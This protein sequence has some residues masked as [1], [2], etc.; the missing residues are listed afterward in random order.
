MNKLVEYVTAAEKRS[1]RMD[2][3]TDNLFSDMQRLML[4][5]IERT[6]KGKKDAMLKSAERIY[7]SEYWNNFEKS[8]NGQKQT[9]L[10]K[11]YKI[12][13]AEI[14]QLKSIYPEN[15][16][17][18]SVLD[19]AFEIVERYIRE[20][21]NALDIISSSRSE[22]LGYARMAQA[23]MFLSEVDDLIIDNIE[24]TLGKQLSYTKTRVKFAQDHYY[25]QIRQQLFMSVKTSKKKQ[26]MYV[27]VTD[28]KTRPFC[29][30]NV[31]K[32]RTKAEWQSINNRMTG[33]AWDDD[34]G[35]NCRH[36]KVLVSESWTAEEI[37]E[38]EEVFLYKAA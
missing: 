13:N 36:F 4:K 18:S 32:I 30:E 5:S 1:A 26:Y 6:L 29:R 28:S 15:T 21:I 38:A 7:T 20:D 11:F 16:F 9:L 27:G 17:K 23:K 33:N 24:K 10:D 37:K 8:F 14:N 12:F 25:N 19:S 31:G 35:W 34:G 3:L 2:T 22:V